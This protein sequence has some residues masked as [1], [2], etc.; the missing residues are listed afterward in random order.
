[1]SRQ[2]LLGVGSL[3]LG[4]G[5]S[6]WGLPQMRAALATKSWPATPGKVISS[7]IEA[8]GSDE[9]ATYYNRISY[10]YEVDGVA[11]TSNRIRTGPE[12]PAWSQASAM[13][14][15]GKYAEGM[16]VKVSY[17]PNDPSFAILEPGISGESIIGLV[18]G[19]FLLALGL[20]LTFASFGVRQEV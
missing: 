19:L 18:V 11:Y 1:M 12:A 3:V 20:L 16:P 10:S 17:D 4:A 15:A 14:I 8:H 13:I 5:I 7:T 6:L 9:D 2:K